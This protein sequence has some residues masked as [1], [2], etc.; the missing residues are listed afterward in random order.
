[1]AQTEIKTDER[2]GQ[3]HISEDIKVSYALVHT[4][5]KTLSDL[6]RSI[7]ELAVLVEGLKK[8]SAKIAVDY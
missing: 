8:Q 2:L 1:M 4:A 5:Q 6:D 3:E 7:L